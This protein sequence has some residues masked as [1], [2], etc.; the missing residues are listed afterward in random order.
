MRLGEGQVNQQ[1]LRLLQVGEAVGSTFLDTAW[2]EAS[3]SGRCDE[4]GRVELQLQGGG[5]LT[6]YF[7]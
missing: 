2:Q 7:I 4:S 3:S 5:E 1:I 6:G